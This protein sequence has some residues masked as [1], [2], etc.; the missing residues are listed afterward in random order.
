MSLIFCASAD[1]ESYEHSSR[2]F[3]PLIRWLFPNLSAAHVEVLHY[4]FR[5]ACHLSEYAILAMLLWRAIHSHRRNNHH[6]LWPEA[7]LAVA[8]VFLYAATDELHQVFVPTRTG[9]VSDIFIDTGGGA[10]GMLLLWMAGKL[11]KRW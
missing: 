7:G 5:K 9:M 10:A 6:W 1:T 8:I 11:F 4:L 3:E 2:Y